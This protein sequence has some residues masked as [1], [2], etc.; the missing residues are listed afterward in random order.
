MVK[1]HTR[2]KRRLPK[3]PRGRTSRPKTFKTEA[4]A[5]AH[6]EKRGIKKYS[7]VDLKP[8]AETHKFRIVSE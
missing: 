2:I 5:K 6:A 3:S 7:L 8:S 4:A 1:V